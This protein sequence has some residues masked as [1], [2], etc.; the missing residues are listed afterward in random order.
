MKTIDTID[1]LKEI[2]NRGRVA[3]GICCL[4]SAAGHFQLNKEKWQLVFDEVWK[5]CSSDMALWQERFGELIPFAVSEKVEFSIKD[6]QYF[7]K[8]EHDALQALY[9][10]TDP[11]ILD[12]INLIYTIGRTNINVTVRN[13]ALKMATI[14]Y[15]QSL[16]E[17]MTKNNV[18]L[19]DIKLFKKFPITDNRGW[20][21]TFVREDVFKKEVK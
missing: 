5:F 1:E 20:G 2:S 7:T 4:E 12:I 18:P 11:L 9:E 14:P 6:Y 16:M 21:W 10:K 19:P 3:F 13:E 8:E 15:L 17:M